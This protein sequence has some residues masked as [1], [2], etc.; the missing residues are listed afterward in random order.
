MVRG[1][2]MPGLSFNKKN[3]EIIIIQ[4]NSESIKSYME[5]KL[6]ILYFFVTVD[7]V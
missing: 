4:K 3:I 6:I 5:V 7:T 1:K 2:R